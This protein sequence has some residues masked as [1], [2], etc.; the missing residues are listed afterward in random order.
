[1]FGSSGNV[2]VPLRNK[3]GEWIKNEEPQYKSAERRLVEDLA[4]DLESLSNDVEDLSDDLEDLA[5]DLEDLSNDLEDLSN[6][7][8]KASKPVES[9]ATMRVELWLCRLRPPVP[10]LFLGLATCSQGARRGGAAT[11]EA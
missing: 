9:L 11:K 8:E 10:N 1:M 4:D 6:S 5:D 3:K 7:M 2:V